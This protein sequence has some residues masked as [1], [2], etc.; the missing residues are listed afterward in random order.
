MIQF[1]KLPHHM[2]MSRNIS[3]LQREMHL[4]RPLGLS[5]PPRQL[6][7]FTLLLGTE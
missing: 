3:A 2:D 6:D 4:P 5:A 1:M 7:T